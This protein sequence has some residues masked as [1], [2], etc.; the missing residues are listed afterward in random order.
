LLAFFAAVCYGKHIRIALSRSGISFGAASSCSIIIFDP[1]NG[2]ILDLYCSMYEFNLVN[3]NSESN[4]S[5]WGDFD[6]KTMECSNADF[7]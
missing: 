3:C 2:E 1:G 7:K 4:D 6:G 5:A